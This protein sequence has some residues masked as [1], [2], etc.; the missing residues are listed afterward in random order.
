MERS[1]KVRAGDVAA[2]AVVKLSDGTFGVVLQGF[3]MQSGVGVDRWHAPAAFL[4]AD[5]EVELVDALASYLRIPERE[6][7]AGGLN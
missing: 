7:E 3:G 5:E 4:P 2:G 6:L 1:P